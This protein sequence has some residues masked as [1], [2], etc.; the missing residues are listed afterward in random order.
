MAELIDTAVTAAGDAPASLVLA[1]LVP[2]DLAIDAVIAPK[3]S[4]AT[5]QNAVPVLRELRVV[6]LRGAP[7]GG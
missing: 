3:V 2:A 7:A 1:D 6:N 5:H 4:F